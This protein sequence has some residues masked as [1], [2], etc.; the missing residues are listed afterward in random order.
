M[1]NKSTLRDKRAL[2]PV[3]SSIIMIA[4][5]V[6]VSVGV[7]TWMGSMFTNLIS[8]EEFTITDC[9]LAE[10]LSYADLIIENHGTNWLVLSTVMV[11][12]ASPEYMSIIS[13]TSKLD[14]GDTAVVRVFQGFRTSTR[15]RFRVL[16]ARGNEADYVELTG[17]TSAASLHYINAISNVDS[18]SDKGTHSNFVNQQSGPDNVF[19]I[20]TEG[21]YGAGLTNIVQY[22][23]SSSSDVDFSEDSGIETN[24]VNSQDYGPDNDFMTIQEENVGGAGG[25][26][27]SIRSKTHSAETSDRTSHDI[28]LPE[29]I[30]AGDTL[31]VVFVCDDNEAVTWENEGT[32]WNVIYEEDAGSSGPTMSIAWKKAVGN[33]DGTT[34]TVTTGGSEQSVHLSYAIKD[35]ND[36]TVYP[37]EASSESS[38][39][40]DSPNPASLSPSGG[41][42]GYLWF[43]F[44][45]CDDDDVASSYPSSYADN[46]ETYESSSGYGTCATGAASRDYTSSSDNPGSF[47]I[48]SE[49]WEAAT[50]A[51]YSAPSEDNFELD[52]EYQWTSADFDETDERVC[53]YVQTASQ[54]GEN[55]V[56][57]E[58]NG[59]D[60][61]SLGTL[62]F[63]GWN[64]FT[65]LHLTGA[66]YTIS[67]RD[68]NKSNDA[69]QSSWN[70]DCIITDCSSTETNYELDMEVQFSDVD[71]GRGYN[72]ICI[73]MGSISGED[74]D[75]YIWNGD[76]WDLLATDLVQN[77]WNN[78]TRSITEETITLRFLGNLETTD[79]VQD[80]WEID[81][82][83][84]YAPPQ[85]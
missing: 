43:A 40:S 84:L 65:T 9:Q 11:N 74:L 32:D 81:C 20:L 67:I 12:G 24:F 61:Q 54:S 19:D 31:L 14:P 73:Y 50:V 72:E 35:A 26:Y 53:I 55:L 29:T 47:T 3:I 10:D 27:P 1:L 58:W 45:G 80:T 39:Y 22:A 48:S 82:V 63:D 68:E 2:S 38:G 46:R 51:V 60:W 4:I 62:S 77:Q 5:T 78:I 6:T 71:V 64:N 57:Y 36:P 13:G 85:L 7:S 8:L 30:E 41:S 28:Q 83:L 44:Y 15:Y 49:Q 42:K 75:T 76:S 23:D 16:S 79:A 34:I 17:S 37:P 56:A 52:F 33:E 21:N 25:E 66:T 70:I 18:S 59:A 69:A